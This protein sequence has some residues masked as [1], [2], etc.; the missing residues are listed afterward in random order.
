MVQRSRTSDEKFILVA[1]Q[2]AKAADD[3][4]LVMN[5]YEI[6]TAAG[7]AVKATDTICKTLMQTNFI[8]KVNDVD[9]R[10]TKNGENLA[11]RLL[12]E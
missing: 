6:G 9:V 1:Y 2:K 5:R 10:L 12:D 4:D 7:M 11:L 3:M 8:K